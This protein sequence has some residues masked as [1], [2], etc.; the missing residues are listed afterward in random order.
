MNSDDFI[1]LFVILYGYL[2]VGV[3][4]LLAAFVL[5]CITSVNLKKNKTVELT[6]IM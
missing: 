2:A 3:L 1:G 4:F 5:A 6:L